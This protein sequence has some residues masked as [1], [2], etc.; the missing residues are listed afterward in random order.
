MV[1]KRKRIDIQK[2]MQEEARSIP[3]VDSKSWQRR[4][5]PQ[6]MGY[7]ISLLVDLSGSMER[8]K[9]LRRHSKPLLS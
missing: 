7:A 3:V 8:D 2:R 9:R 5:L 4:E 1:L 6:E